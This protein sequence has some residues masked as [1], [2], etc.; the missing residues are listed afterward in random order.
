MNTSCG[1][2]AG[3]VLFM[4]VLSLIHILKMFYLCLYNVHHHDMFSVLSVKTN[5]QLEGEKMCAVG[6]C[7]RIIACVDVGDAVLV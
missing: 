7:V 6:L 4:N 1:F 3:R 5:E 2:R